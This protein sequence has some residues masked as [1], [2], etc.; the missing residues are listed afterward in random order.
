MM[1]EISLNVL[2]VTENSVS[3]GATRIGISVTVDSPADTLTIVI[4]DNGCGMSEET[5]RRVIDPFYTTRKTRKVGLGVPFFK[6]AAELSGGRF[7]IDSKE[8]EGTV[9]TAVCGRTNIDRM[10]L[11]DMPSTIHTLVTMHEAIDFCYTFRYDEEEFTLDTAEMREVLGGI[12]FAEPEVSAYLREYL[13][14]NTAEVT[15]GRI[16]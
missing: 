15:R 5:V 13:T 16:L 8:G 14:E 11:G 7:E 10:P 6:L 1:P 12:S 9:G 4:S 2:D 3:A